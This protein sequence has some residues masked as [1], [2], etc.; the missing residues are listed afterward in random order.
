MW[1][2][3]FP[4]LSALSFGLGPLLCL[5][6][7]RKRRRGR[8]ATVVAVAVVKPREA[9]ETKQ[10]HFP[11]WLLLDCFFPRLRRRLRLLPDVRRC[12]GGSPR[13]GG[14]FSPWKGRL[15]HAIQCGTMSQELRQV[16]RPPSAAERLSRL[17]LGSRS[18][19]PRAGK[20]TAQ[21]NL[22][23]PVFLPSSSPVE[24]ELCQKMN[25]P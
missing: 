5:R 23:H 3:L 21:N 14:I 20:D 15:S 22:S 16:L 24:L 11:R 6:A 17:P 7:R 8:K 10:Q 2:F 12:L 1:R 18:L 25:Y 9:R 13:Q 19:S 4:L